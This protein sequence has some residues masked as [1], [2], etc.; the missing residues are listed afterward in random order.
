MCKNF[1]PHFF[2]EGV[3]IV[4]NIC[5]VSVNMVGTPCGCSPSICV[6]EKSSI[7]KA[8]N[9]LPIRCQTSLLP[10]VEF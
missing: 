10:S 7:F 1:G 8:N 9:F 4:A 3:W 5:N 6:S 2:F